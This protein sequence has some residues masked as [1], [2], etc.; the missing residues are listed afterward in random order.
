MAGEA[1]R[2][3]G[4]GAFSGEELVEAARDL[5]GDLVQEVGTFVDRHPAPRPIECRVCSGDG[6]IDL[7]LA[8]FVHPTDDRVIDRRALLELF[9]RGDK[10]AVDE[11]Q[12]LFHCVDF[13]VVP[14]CAY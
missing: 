2:L 10:L 3:A 13:L 7:G 4:I 11:I 5:V 8:G 6:R 1:F 9:R 12:D 14:V